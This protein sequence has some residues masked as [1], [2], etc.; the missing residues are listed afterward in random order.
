MS[1]LY[2]VYIYAEI[3]VTSTHECFVEKKLLVS[4]WED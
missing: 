1:I 4:I 2:L 3:C